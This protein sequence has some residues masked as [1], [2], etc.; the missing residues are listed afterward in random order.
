MK[1]VKVKMNKSIYLGMTIL[2]ISKIPKYEFWYAY[3]KPKYKENLQ[4][5]YMDTDSYIFSVKT[6][7]WYKDI[8][9]DVEK[10]FDT[11]SIQSN[12]PLKTGINK[13]V[14][15]MWKDELSLCYA[16]LVDNENIGK[17]AKGVK[18]CVKKR[19]KI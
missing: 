6:K 5:H 7:N 9:N 19:S 13:K 3:L 12:I 10:L 2:D 18:K 1:K 11:S 14:L 8:S 15:W 16:Y 4:L 17:R